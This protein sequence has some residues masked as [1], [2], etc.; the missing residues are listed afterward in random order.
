MISEDT[1]VGLIDKR[2][3]VLMEALESQE[4][5]AL[6]NALYNVIVGVLED[7]KKEIKDYV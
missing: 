5:D 2:V 4:C 3:S 6:D 7:L 1:V